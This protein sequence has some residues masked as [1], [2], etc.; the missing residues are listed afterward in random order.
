MSF[1][2]RLR[3]MA[4]GL[5]LLLVGDECKKQPNNVEK[6]KFMNSKYYMDLKLIV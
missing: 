6:I 5:M 2:G 3:S 4:S 1:A